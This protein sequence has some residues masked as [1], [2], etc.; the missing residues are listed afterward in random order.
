ML[1]RRNWLLQPRTKESGKATAAAAGH[2][3]E[4][5]SIHGSNCHAH[6]IKN[7]RFGRG[8]RKSGEARGAFEVVNVVMVGSIQQ[9]GADSK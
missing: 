2:E 4:L 1:C 8:F 6:R 5:G 3:Q 7:G 9:V